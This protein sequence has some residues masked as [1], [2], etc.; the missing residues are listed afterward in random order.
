M[1]VSH[2]T[3]QFAFGYLSDRK[4]PLDILAS[5]STMM[6][7]VTTVTMWRLPGCFSVLI[8]YTI[9]YGFFGAG[10]T[11]IWARMS[12]TITDD[13]TAGPIVFG[14]LNLGKGVKNVLTGPIGGL[15]VHDNSA[16]QHLSVVEF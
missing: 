9:L 14:L 1:S 12:T 8:G 16:L 3:G 15:L 11:A 13:A 5:S 4:I 10:F 2:V 7:A 6:A